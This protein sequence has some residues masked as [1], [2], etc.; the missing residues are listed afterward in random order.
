MFGNVFTSNFYSDQQS[1]PV[2]CRV[3]ILTRHYSAAMVCV[4][5]VNFAESF[6]TTETMQVTRASGVLVTRVTGVCGN[7]G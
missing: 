2:T 5:S 1:K 6:T 3:N 4:C 7:Q